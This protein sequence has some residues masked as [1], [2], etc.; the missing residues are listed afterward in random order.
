MTHTDLKP[1][2]MAAA[3]QAWKREY[4]QQPPS[5]DALEMALRSG[6]AVQNARTPDTA[7]STDLIAEA[8]AN[9]HPLA[10]AL[11]E[12]LI[13]ALRAAEAR[14]KVLREAIK[15]ALSPHTKSI[16]YP[17]G[18]FYD[19]DCPRCHAQETLSRALGGEP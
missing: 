1:G 9:C 2:V 18:H 16:V 6:I 19:A 15:Q 12:R 8:E 4:G 7:P 11:V 17:H 10:W 3:W 13:T 5:A 14:E